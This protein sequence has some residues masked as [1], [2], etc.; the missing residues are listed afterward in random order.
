MCMKMAFKAMR[1]N[2][3][4]CEYGKRKRNTPTFRGK[5]N[6]PTFRGQRYTVKQQMGLKKSNQRDEQKTKRDNVEVRQ[7]NSFE[8]EGVFDSVTYRLKKYD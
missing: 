8:E 2:E 1:L 3:M 5:R 4:T 7:R 6:T